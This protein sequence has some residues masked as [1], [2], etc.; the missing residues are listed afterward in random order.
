M[1]DGTNYYLVQKS[2]KAN[3]ADAKR[4]D[5]CSVFYESNILKVDEWSVSISV[6]KLAAECDLCPTCLA[7]IIKKWLGTV[8]EVYPYD[9]AR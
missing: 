8:V 3:M 5:N 2:R 1:I 9:G 6:H 7:V 4:C